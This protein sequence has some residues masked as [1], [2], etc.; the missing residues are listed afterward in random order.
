MGPKKK[1][2][3][4][5]IKNKRRFFFP[6]HQHHYHY[7]LY[8]LPLK[9]TIGVCT[10]EPHILSFSMM[11]NSNWIPWIWRSTFFFFSLLRNTRM[12]LK[13]QRRKLHRWC[14]DATTWIKWFEI[15]LNVQ[16]QCNKQTTWSKASG[17]GKIRWNWSRYN[18]CVI[19]LFRINYVM[20]H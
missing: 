20:C 9:F 11:N 14:I 15:N 2:D 4:Q 6:L 8:C 19:E 18:E 3:F 5:L 13:T 10:R 7:H 1:Q 12:R 17:E 16:H